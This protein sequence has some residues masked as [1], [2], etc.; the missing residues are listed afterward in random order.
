LD[1]KNLRFIVAIALFGLLFLF[2]VPIVYD[3]TMFQCANPRVL[4]PWNPSGLKSLGYTFF[5]WGGFYSFGGAGDPQLSGYGFVPTGIFTYVNGS[6]PTTSAILFFLA[7]PLAIAAA[8]LLEPEIVRKFRVA[9][10]GFVIL[11]LFALIVSANFFS[12][13]YYGYG[14]AFDLLG[15]ALSL[16]GAGMILYMYSAGCFNQAL[17]PDP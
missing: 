11:G 14:L 3:A 15:V 2:F 9:V 5:H 1:P 16:M 13:A 10:I 17:R 7:L 4:C 8:G 6:I 12:L